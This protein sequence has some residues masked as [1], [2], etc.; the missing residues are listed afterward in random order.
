[1][2]S[3]WLHLAVEVGLLGLLAYLA[4]LVLLALPLIRSSRR[5]RRDDV[6][7]PAE[8]EATGAWAVGALVFAVIVA[9]LSPALEDPL[10]PPLLFGIV[11][12]AWVLN[13]RRTVSA[14]PAVQPSQTPDGRLASSPDAS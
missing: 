11:G 13:A 14:A 5:Y 7:G 10:F 9:A 12:I 2:D 8:T 4:W 3:F 1:V 6:E